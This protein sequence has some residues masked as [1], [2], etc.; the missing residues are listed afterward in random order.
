ME[1]NGDFDA[2]VPEERNQP[3]AWGYAITLNELPNSPR[4]FH[5]EVPNT[6]KNPLTLLEP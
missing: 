5:A 4:K 2:D 6:F 3:A 1:T